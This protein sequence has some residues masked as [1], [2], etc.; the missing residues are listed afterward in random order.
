MYFD[1]GEPPPVDG[2]SSLDEPPVGRAGSEAPAQQGATMGVG[3]AV[4]LVAFDHA[5]WGAVEGADE[6]GFRNLMQ[7]VDR[8]A[9]PRG[10]PRDGQRACEAHK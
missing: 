1:A 8:L 10:E 6:G 4:A 9:R 2:G 3:H 7:T 5:D